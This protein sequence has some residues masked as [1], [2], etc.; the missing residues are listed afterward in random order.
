M[1]ARLPRV[2]R[3][4]ATNVTRIRLVSAW[5]SPNLIDDDIFD[6]RLNMQGVAVRAG[7]MLSDAVSV[8]LTYARGWRVDDNLGTGGNGGSIGINPLDNYQLF[9]ADLNLK[10]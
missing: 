4:K 1:T 2:I 5:D 8:N 10:F 9:Q 7:Y 3:T 6:A